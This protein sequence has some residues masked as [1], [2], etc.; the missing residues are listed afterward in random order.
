[1]ARATVTA[2]MA[3]KEGWGIT[4]IESNAAGTPVVGSNVQGL[5]DSILDGKTGLL[6]E[7]G[8]SSDLAQKI[9]S[10]LKDRERLQR[11]EA[12]ARAWAATFTWERSAEYFLERAEQEIAAEK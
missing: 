5:R 1:M 8:S 7:P 6:A 12:E 3:E 4:V 2:T 9:I 10:L 11:M